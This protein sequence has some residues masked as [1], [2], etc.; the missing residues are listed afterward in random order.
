MYKIIKD[1][2][3]IDVVQYADFI[4][5]L[6]TGQVSRTD[7]SLAQGIIGSDYQTIYSFISVPNYDRVSIEKISLEEFNRLYSLLNSDKEIV[8]DE[9]LLDKV[10]AE[11]ISSLSVTCKNKIISGFSIVLSDGALHNFRLTPEDQINLLNLEN[12]LNTGVTTFIYHSTNTPC[13]VFTRNDIKKV[14]TTYRKYITYHTTYFNA[15]KQYI[16]SITD[17]NKIKAFSYGLDISMF[18]KE[19]AIKQILRDGGIN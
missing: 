13:K 15:A 8:S 18:I 1:N 2:K 17:I 7:E 12:Q 5:F 19:N 14:I 11:V 6:P 10:R 3:I 9:S 16:N 4:R